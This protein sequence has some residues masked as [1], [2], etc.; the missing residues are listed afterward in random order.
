VVLAVPAASRHSVVNAGHR[1]ASTSSDGSNDTMKPLDELTQLQKKATNAMRCHKRSLELPIVMAGDFNA[2]SHQVPMVPIRV[3]P[4]RPCAMAAP[5][6]W[7]SDDGSVDHL[8][9]MYSE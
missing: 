6:T 3:V 9:A 2:V 5:S 8:C 4:R 7:A 1:S